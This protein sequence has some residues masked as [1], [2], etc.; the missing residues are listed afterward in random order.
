V[1][2]EGLG[3]GGCTGATRA[4]REGEEREGR[5]ERGTHHGFDGR[6]QLLTRIHPTAGR[7][8]ER[9][10]RGRGRLLRGKEKMGK[11]HAWGD[12]GAWATCPGPGWTTGLADFPLLDLAY[13]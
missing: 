12:R 10:G 4:L 11:G 5:E 1:P 2:G 13:F 7:E 8:V 9:C 3:R 6:Q